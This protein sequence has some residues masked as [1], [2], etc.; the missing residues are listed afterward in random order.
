M[1]WLIERIQEQDEKTV[2]VGRQ[3]EWTGTQLTDQITCYLQELKECVRPGGVV[4][5]L[6]DYSFYSISLFLALLEIKCVIVPI[7][8][9]IEHEIH[10]RLKESY[11]DWIIKVT[12]GKLFFERQENEGKHDLLTRMIAEKRSGLVLFSSGSTGKPKAM[13]HDLD[14]LVENYRERKPKKL[15]ILVF[16]MFDHIGGL[17]T[18]LSS[19]SMGAKMIIPGTR[20]VSGVCKLIEKYKIRV[21]PTSPTFLNLILIGN[22]LEKYDLSS[23]KL[24]S[25]GTE[26]M[27]ESLLKRLKHSFPKTRFLQTFGTSETGIVQTSSR[28]S[29]SLEIRLNDPNQEY[30]IVNGELWLRSRVQVLGYL[31]ANMDDFTDD[32]WFNT[33]DLV[34]ECGEG[35]L[36]IIGRKKEVINV[37]GEK[38]LPN[39]V[40]SIVFEM[41]VIED[42]QAYGEANPITGQSVVVDVAFKP[43][44]NA[45]EAKMLVKRH[46][47][48]RMNNYKVPTKINI[49]ESIAFNDRFKKKRLRKN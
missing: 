36:K 2:I 5:I 26:S 24:I 33:G 8:S 14:N 41:E 3:V 37:G 35:Y 4:A 21:L 47:R 15:T 28:S 1:H 44:I 29:A 22:M 31:N 11:C 10:D 17:N 19:L 13:I 39:E 6:A 23:L 7:V 9:K 25:Y 12:D 43:G 34:E 48:K 30:K 49:V 27:P 18:M 20:D 40:E 32:G 46:C 38:V 42:V 45:K 16:L